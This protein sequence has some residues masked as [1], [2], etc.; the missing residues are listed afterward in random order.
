M[1]PA[2]GGAAERSLY[3]FALAALGCPALLFG[4]FQLLVRVR[5]PEN[6]LSESA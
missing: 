6:C 1:I 3:V 2:A 4:L 5:V